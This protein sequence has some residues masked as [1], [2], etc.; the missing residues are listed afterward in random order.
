MKRIFALIL[1]AALALSLAGC[2]GAA[3]G[4]EAGAPPQDPR[5]RLHGRRERGSCGADRAHGD[6]GLRRAQGQLR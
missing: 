3:S 1:A 5:S 2:G 6:L 4:G